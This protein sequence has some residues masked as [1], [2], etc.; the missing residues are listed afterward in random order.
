M[1]E[2]AQGAPIDRARIGWSVAAGLVVFGLAMVSLLELSQVWPSAVQGN[3]SLAVIA[4]VIALLLGLTAARL[5]TGIIRASVLT[6]TT[7]TT[8]GLIALWKRPWVP[9][10]LIALALIMFVALAFALL[11][12]VHYAGVPN[13][14]S[15][16]VLAIAGVVALLG[17]LALV[18]VSFSSVNMADKSQ[19]LALPQGSVRAVIAL[20][21]VVLFAILTVYLFSSLNG[22]QQFDAVAT[23]LNA[24]Q[25]AQV[26]SNPPS[27]E[28][29][30][31]RP[32]QSCTGFDAANPLYD[33]VVQHPLSPAGIDFA[34]QLLVMIGTLVT[35]VASFYFG[36]KAVG[37]ARDVAAGLNVQPVL[38]G[39]EPPTLTQG[40]QDQSLD[41]LGTGLNG[42]RQVQITRGRDQLNAISVT[43]NDNRVHAKFNVPDTAPVGGNGWD[44]TVTDGQG[45]S[46]RL[47]AAVTIVG[48]ELNRWERG[49]TAEA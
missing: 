39:V 8:E 25:S 37:E 30:I 4:I 9:W 17:S 27:S 12:I 16:P 24:A 2:Q 26:V 31:R 40:G 10:A 34:K 13:E 1:A 20:S 38:H 15:L 6:T 41:L 23:C 49:D 32:D 11:G 48:Q 36:S 29:L 28:P 44:V 47:P 42:A 18:A 35:S 19:P 33:V 14:L 21:L 7:T 43:S 45:R 46:F 3:W 22:P 5:T